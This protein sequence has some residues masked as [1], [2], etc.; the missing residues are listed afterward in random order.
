MPTFH[1]YFAAYLIAIVFFFSATQNKTGI[2]KWS[3]GIYDQFPSLHRWSLTKSYGARIIN[4]MR[5]LKRQPVG[6]LVKTDE[7]SIQSVFEFFIEKS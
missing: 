1:R 6:I 2:L 3:Y 4:I 5:T 7:V